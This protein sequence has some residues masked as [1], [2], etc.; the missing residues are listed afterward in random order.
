MNDITAHAPDTISE[1]HTPRWPPQHENAPVCH[2]SD[3][4][5]P[6]ISGIPTGSRARRLVP[7]RRSLGDELKA[8]Y[9]AANI[10]HISIHCSSDFLPFRWSSSAD[11]E[12]HWQGAPFWQG[13]WRSSGRESAK[14]GEDRG[15]CVEIVAK[16]FARNA[17]NCKLILHSAGGA[18][19]KAAGAVTFLAVT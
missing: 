18:A 19:R 3:S 14:L 1:K 12:R 16:T 8:R 7:A 6:H 5:T 4:Y 10:S 9:I 13:A 15:L 2:E 17:H 11:C